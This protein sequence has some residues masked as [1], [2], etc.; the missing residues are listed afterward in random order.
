[1]TRDPGNVSSDYVRAVLPDGSR[2]VMQIPS[3]IAVLDQVQTD[4]LPAS[5]SHRL[6]I[7]HEFHPVV[8]DRMLYILTEDVQL[9]QRV[10]PYDSLP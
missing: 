2:Q 3:P 5:A 4:N 7:H 8:A 10:V 9:L 1:M 6:A